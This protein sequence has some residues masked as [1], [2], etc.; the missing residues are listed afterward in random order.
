MLALCMLGKNF[1]LQHFEIFF[2]FFVENK[3]SIIG[4]LSAEFAHNMVSVKGQKSFLCSC[5]IWPWGYK[6][7][8]MLNS[9]EHEIFDANM[10]MQE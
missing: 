2:L 9:A 10:K 7:F 3:K 1:K 6:T 8:F 4:L 5:L